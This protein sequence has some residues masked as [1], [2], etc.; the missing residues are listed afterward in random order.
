MSGRVVVVS[1]YFNPIHSGHLDY[2]EEAKKLGDYLVV[3]VN[4]DNQ[5]QMKG[6]DPFMSE[7][8]R[9][10][11]ARALRCVDKAV[12]A[13]DEDGTVCQSLRKEYYQLQD[14]P[15]FIGMA[16]ANG[17]DRKEGGVP[18]DLLEEELGIKMVYN[19]GGNKTQ[20]SSNLLYKSKIRGA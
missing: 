14:D 19:V 11:I 7:S 16:F 8:E 17:G 5:V 6:S 9:L 20:S 18:E 13:I 12:V 3:I 1:G 10:R 2:L 15:F 4:S